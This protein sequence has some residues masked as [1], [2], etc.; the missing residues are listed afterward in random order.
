MS[1]VKLSPTFSPLILSCHRREM[2]IQLEILLNLASKSKMLGK[3][4][5]SEQARVRQSTNS[6]NKT[7]SKTQK[8]KKVQSQRLSKCR[9]VHTEH[10]FTMSQ[11]CESVYIGCDCNC[12][13]VGIIRNQV[14]VSITLNLGS[15]CH[16]LGQ[17]CLLAAVC[18]GK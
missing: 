13:Q 12:E 18:S 7:G 9:Y 2:Q 16:S 5:N 10:Y 15:G 17:T 8:Y 6:V 1:I 3:I 11:C 4:L 14:T